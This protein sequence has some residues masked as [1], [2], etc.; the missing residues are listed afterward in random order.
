MLYLFIFKVLNVQTMFKSMC[1]VT[2]FVLSSCTTTYYVV[3][4]AEKETATTMSSDVPLS[5][6]GRQRAEALKDELLSHN[7]KH[8]FATPTRRTTATLQLLS[9]AIHIPIIAYSNDTLNQ[10]INRLRAI[11]NSN[12]VIA[13]H[14]NTVDDIVNKLSGKKFIA[15]NL[16]ETAFGD[17]F[18]VKRKGNTYTFFKGHFGE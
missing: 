9:N 8:L 18:V 15:G 7:I 13:G 17:L 3:R 5:A 11:K 16:P 2:V 12:V 4:H 1:I 6:T 14:S 10:F